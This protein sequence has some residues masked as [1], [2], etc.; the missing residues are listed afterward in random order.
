[1]SAV[2]GRL[3]CA[4]TESLVERLARCV[5]AAYVVRT[6]ETGLKLLAPESLT[7]IEIGTVWCYEGD[8]QDGVFRCAPT[9]EGKTGPREF[10]AA[11]RVLRSM[12]LLEKL[13]R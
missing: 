5:Q 10:L 2:A 11:A 12:P 4:V 13:H 1:M 6:E 7:H 8:D 3:G 9:G